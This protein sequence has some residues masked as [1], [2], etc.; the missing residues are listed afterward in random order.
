MTGVRAEH[1]DD[2]EPDVV[3]LRLQL[4]E[5]RDAAIGAEA[6]AGQLRARVKLLELQLDDRTRHA[7]ALLAEVEALRQRVEALEAVARHRDAM[8]ASPT[9]RLGERMLRPMQR[10]RMVLRRG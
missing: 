1:D 7:D 6:K 9:W 5:A 10:L 4:W 3:E 8:L 2:D